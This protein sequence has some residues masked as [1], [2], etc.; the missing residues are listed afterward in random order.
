M[1]ALKSYTLEI[2]FVVLIVAACLTSGVG[3]QSINWSFP[4]FSGAEQFLPEGQWLINKDDYY[5]FSTLSDSDK[6]WFNFS[7]GKSPESFVPYNYYDAGFLHIIILASL[8]LPFLPPIAALVGLQIIVHCLICV[9]VSRKF[10]QTHLKI[11]FFTLYALNPVVLKFVCFSYYYFWQVIPSFFLVLYLLDKKLWGAY[12]L[13]VAITLGV[14]L[15]LRETT[16]LVVLAFLLLSIYREKLATSLFSIFLVISIKLILYSG[17]NA[18]PWHTMY[19]GIGAY[20]NPNNVVLSD[21]AGYQVFERKTTMIIDTN[22][23]TGNFNDPTTKQHYYKVMKQEYLKVLRDSPLLLISNALKNT[24]AGYSF[25]YFVGNPLI[26]KLAMAGGALFV[27]VLFF[28]RQ[29]VW[30]LAIGLSLI[31]FTSFYPPIPAYMYGSYLIIIVA[32]IRLLNQP[33]INSGIS[34]FITRIKK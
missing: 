1:S 3:M 13:P 10:N 17:G 29:Y 7:E 20:G 9:A 14:S 25:G 31:T 19:V 5:I 16:I 33:G 18:S 6:L 21:N 26:Q 30:F 22:P 34:S 28:Y 23:I 8:L 2:F 24:L 32:F 4:Y 11:L 15:G 12:L 27:S